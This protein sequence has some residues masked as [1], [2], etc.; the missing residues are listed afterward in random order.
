MICP[1]CSAPR[2]RVASNNPD[3]KSDPRRNYRRRFCALCGCRWRTVEIIDGSYPNNG[4]KVGDPWRNGASARN[5]RGGSVAARPL[6]PP[7]LSAQS[8]KESP[9]RN[10][11]LDRAKTPAAIAAE[12]R[13]RG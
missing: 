8:P 4:G 9:A 12:L 11:N 10:F 3:G 2:T 13:A 7:P 5:G 1:Y 6:A